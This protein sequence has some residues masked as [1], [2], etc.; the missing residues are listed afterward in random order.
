MP[1]VQ[2]S[3]THSYPHTLPT[4][5]PHTHPAHTPLTPSDLHTQLI[6]T[7]TDAPSPHT[8]THQW[9][10]ED[11][12]DPWTTDPL[13]PLPIL[14]NLIH[15]TPPPHTPLLRLC[16]CLILLYDF[17]FGTF[18]LVHISYGEFWKCGSFDDSMG[19]MGA[20]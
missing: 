11:V 7:F 10:S 19:E 16:T 9:R 15:L 5:T 8:H 18:S 12:R 3:S 13:G 14:H 20:P 4:P 17:K 1:L 2:K 6:N